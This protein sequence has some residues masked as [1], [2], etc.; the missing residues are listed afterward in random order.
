MSN[1]IVFLD[2]ATVDRG[3]LDLARLEALPAELVTFDTTS[4][5]ETGQRIEGA[6][7]VI[8]NKVELDAQLLNQLDSPPR[9]ICLTATGTDNVDIAAAQNRGIAVTNIR[10]Y[11]TASVT[12]HTFALILALAT[13]LPEYHEKLRSGAWAN[14][15]TFT[16]LDLPIFELSGKTL[17]I[18]GFGTLGQSVARSAQAFGMKVLVAEHQ[19]KH[20]RPGRVAFYKALSAADIISLHSPLNDQTRHLINDATIDLMKRSAILI[21]TARGGLIDEQ[22]L[23]AALRAKRLG[24][25]GLDVLSEEPPPPDHPLLAPDLANV[26]ITPH[27][28]WA[29]QEARQ[30]AIDAVAANIRA[31]WAGEMLNRV[32]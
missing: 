17:T 23:V 21:N 4:S 2:F 11:C 13:H 29:S 9:L 20:P 32:A 19:G 14:S 25:A 28:A 26:V 3:D 18:I 10:D 5:R 12:Q 1:R 30:R 22:S 6:D 16:L 8:L 24:G 15:Q 31:Y 7:V 27:I